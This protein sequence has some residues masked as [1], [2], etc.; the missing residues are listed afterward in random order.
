[1]V[2]FQCVWASYGPLEK[3]LPKSFESLEKTLPP[4]FQSLGD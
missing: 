2:C 3:T 4:S 1:M